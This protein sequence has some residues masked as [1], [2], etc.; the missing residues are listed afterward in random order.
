MKMLFFSADQLEVEEVRQSF[1]EAGIQCLVRSG[2][3]RRHGPYA[4][5]EAELWIKDDSDCHRALLLCVQLGV[6]FAKRQHVLNILDIYDY[7][8]EEEKNSNSQVGERTAD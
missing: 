7:P 1:K 4:V 3:S 5:P 2:P 6:G 8:S